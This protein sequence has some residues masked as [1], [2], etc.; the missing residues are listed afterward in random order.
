[1]IRGKYCNIGKSAE[2]VKK[3][4]TRLDEREYYEEI[5]QKKKFR[6]HFPDAVYPPIQESQQNSTSVIDPYLE[7]MKMKTELLLIV[8]ASNEPKMLFDS[9]REKVDSMATA[10]A[11]KSLKRLS[12]DLPGNQAKRLKVDS[13]GPNGPFQGNQSVGSINKINGLQDS[14]TLL[15]LLQT[16]PGILEGK[17][18]SGLDKFLNNQ[19]NHVGQ[20]R[21]PQFAA[22]LLTLLKSKLQ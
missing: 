2:P 18:Y 11:K 5:G 4:K 16:M 10:Y 20:G 9:I 17:E 6:N 21:N 1:L 12:S 13:T 19:Q 3:E 7:L 14:K 22:Q 8:E 15:E